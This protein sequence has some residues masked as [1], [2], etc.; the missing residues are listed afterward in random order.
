MADLELPGYELYERLGRGGMATVY[1]ALHL[2]LDREVAIKVM[3]PG[4]N[5]DESFSER[6]IR[7]ARISARLTHPH[8]LQIYDVNTFDGYNYIAMEL[9]GAGELSDFIHLSMPQK[10]IYTIT[11]QMAEALDYAA[12]RGY[13]HRD[14]KPSNIMM[15]DEG[16]YVLADF[17]IA[18]AANSGTQ[19]TQTGLMVGTPSYMSPEQ[20]KGQEVDGRSDLYALAVLVYEMLTKTLPYESDS[21]VTTAVK[22]LTEDIPTLPEHLAAYQDFINKGLAK[23]ADDRFQTGAELY[24][25]FMAASADFD[26]D[27]VLTEGVE[28]PAAPAPAAA[29]DGPERTSLAGIDSTR[30]SHSSSPAVSGSSRPYKLEGS[31]QRERLVSGTY[32]RSDRAA[33][34]S[35]G[36]VVR[37]LVIV[38]VLAG[39]GYGGFTWWQGQQG[40]DSKDQRALTA[41]L[42]R[43]Y[44]AMNEENLAVAASAFYKVLSMDSGNGAAQQG[45]DEVGNLYTR[46]IEQAIADGDLGS[47]KNLMLDYGGYFAGNSNF[48][49]LQA[50]INLLAE[51]QNLAAVQAERVDKLLSQVD[52]SIET[53]DFDQ[54]HSLMAQAT[55]IDPEHAQLAA[56][57]DAIEQAQAKTAAYEERWSRYTPAQREAFNAAITIADAA[58]DAGELE[59]AESALADA[60]EIA[61]D[62]P[63]LQ[64][65][66]D[67]LE[68]ARAQ[69]LEDLA[70]EEAR[71]AALLDE[72][73]AA[74]AAIAEDPSNAASAVGIYQSVT[75]QYPDNQRANQGIE[76]VSAFYIDVA[77]D[78]AGEGD[79]DGARQALA[80]VETLLPGADA[81]VQFE[82]ELPALEEKWTRQQAELAARREAE[83]AALDKATETAARGERSLA[84]G[85][86]DLA[87]QAYD[88]V[89][90]THPELPAVKLLED[91]LRKAYGDAARQ[92]IDLKEFDSAEDLVTRGKTHFPDDPSWKLLAQ[93]IDTARSSSRR[94]LGAY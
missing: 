55:A 75:E 46:S 94:R 4:M 67:R 22:H 91:N 54:A 59:P 19:M 70:Q 21:A 86:L 24:Q 85:A 69:I 92:E 87:Q 14:I 2:N 66:V 32:A 25:A 72:A 18:R 88:E 84:S 5:A 16:D 89:V 9:L 1:R 62:V 68:A 12:G 50:E 47:A 33:S 27:Q 29:G 82:S 30:L 15:R 20:A 35:G 76:D 8:I 79:F 65:R 38:A 73:D 10:Q 48:E 6:F 23:S 63:E 78:A 71:I 41:E 58:L 44:S 64:R 56:R 53:G 60:A 52:A 34:K 80:T 61:S 51:Q 43:A 93:E 13:V 42:A 49:R 31:T 3:D 37:I 11:R 7:E 26:D 36:S 90:Q 83:K 40:G 39:A 57:R 45:M 28:K 17:G 81:V 77:R 74:V